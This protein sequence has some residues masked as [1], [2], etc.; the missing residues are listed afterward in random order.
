MKTNSDS[1]GKAQDCA[2]GGLIGAELFLGDYSGAQRG[3]HS[4]EAN[5]QT[6]FNRCR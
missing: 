5:S 2:I 1:P 6:V 4:S 3:A